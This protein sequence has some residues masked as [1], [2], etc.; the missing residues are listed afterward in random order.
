[1]EP[2]VN[3][4]MLFKYHCVPSWSLWQ[5][6]CFLNGPIRRL[7]MNGIVRIR[8][9]SLL[10]PFPNYVFGFSKTGRDEEAAPRSFQRAAGQPGAAPLKKCMISC[11][12]SSPAPAVHLPTQYSAL[13]FPGF[14]FPCCLTGCLK[15]GG[16][17]LHEPVS[18]SAEQLAEQE[19]LKKCV[20]S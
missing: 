4:C 9:L 17:A 1:M 16:A 2:N 6:G 18:A 11:S 10:S 3:R 19:L 5:Y 8:I 7:R 14:C 13:A 15:P 12:K 20:T